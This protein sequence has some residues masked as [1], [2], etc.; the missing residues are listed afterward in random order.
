MTARTAASGETR[1]TAGRGD[2]RNPTQRERPLT[3]SSTPLTR[4]WAY[5]VAVVAALTGLLGLLGF[6]NSFAAVQTA[7]APSFGWWAWTIP[8]GIDVAIAVFSAADIVLARLNMR[9][10]WLRIVPWTMVAATI[11]LNVAPETSW[12]GRVA[13]TALPLLWVIAVEVGTH[14]VRTWTGLAAADHMDRIRPS[15]WILAPLPTLVLWR[16]AVLWEVL[17]RSEML[18]RERSRLLARADMREAHGR[19]WRW[20]AP[21]RA[22]VL[23]RL[24]EHAEPGVQP[25]VPP[26]VPVPGSGTEVQPAPYPRRELE[27]TGTDATP[28]GK[29]QLARIIALVPG[30]DPR[31]NTD[32]ANE[33]ADACGLSPTTARKYVSQ[34]RGATT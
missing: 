25:G 27:G 1:K 30:D 28:T 12:I 24:G 5:A 26:A 18:T 3:P 19:L 4:G 8:L 17:R 29:E 7:V 23:Y 2:D 9:P 16:R 14:A 13:H 20:K 21:Y 34:M 31:T 15:R 33:Y 32:L 10:R 11:Y 22:R 6:V